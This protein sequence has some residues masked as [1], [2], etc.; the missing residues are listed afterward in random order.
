MTQFGELDIV[1]HFAL[2]RWLLLAFHIFASERLSRSMILYR[3][4]NPLIL[5]VESCFCI[6]I[7]GN[8]P[9]ET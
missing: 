7:Y 9:D 5:G 6:H 8:V 1:G 3:W 4:R 2:A